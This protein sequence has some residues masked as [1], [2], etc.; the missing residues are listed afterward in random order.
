M[1]IKDDVFKK[2][3]VENIFPP[4]KDS[5]DKLYVQFSSQ[6]SVNIIYS[7]AKYL[8]KDQRLVPYIPL[9]FYERYR[10]M[11]GLAY[12]LR[13][14]ETKYKTRVKTGASDLIL[15]KKKLGE[16]TWIAGLPPFNWDVRRL[17]PSHLLHQLTINLNI[18]PKFSS[19]CH[20]A[21]IKTV[22]VRTRYAACRIQ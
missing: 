15:Y 16:S 7:P 11:E 21:P 19:T 1:K 3:K 14:S 5:W 20:H 17:G 18:F 2:M 13:H 8:R 6:T 4:A 9:Q 22:Q 12:E 10:A